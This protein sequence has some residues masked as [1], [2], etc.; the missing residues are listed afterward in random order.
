MSSPDR[1]TL[2]SSLEI[3]VRYGDA[4][5]ERLSELRA[6]L[7]RLE[8]VA[9]D[10]VEP[11]SEPIET[12]H[13]AE[14]VFTEDVTELPAETDVSEPVVAVT[15]APEVVSAAPE[16]GVAAVRHWAVDDDPAL[17]AAFLRQQFASTG[18]GSEPDGDADETPTASKRTN[19]AVVSFDEDGRITYCNE[20]M[21]KLLIDVDGPLV[22][23]RIWEHLPENVIDDVRAVVDRVLET[24]TATT[25]D[26]G[27]DEYGQQFALTVFPSGDGVSVHA[28]THTPREPRPQGRSLY[29]YLI[30]TVGDAV[31]ILDT[32]GRFTFVNEA[33]CEMTGYDRETLIGSS[34]HLIKDDY[35]VEEAEDAL[36]DLLRRRHDDNEEGIGIAKLDVELVTKDGRHI[37]CTDRM[38]LRPM[39]NGEFTGTV[40]TLRDISRQ[41]RRENILGGLLEAAGEMVTAETLEAV[42]ESVLGTAA[43]T[44]DIELATIREYD[45]ETDR[46]VPVVS[47]EAV[48]EVLPERPVYDAD[49]G[50]VGTAFS[51]G[52]LVVEEDMFHL[53][54][55]L[56]PVESSV[57][58][59]LG[60]RRTLSVGIPEG[61]DFDEDERRFVELLAATAA[62]V[63]DRVE[64]EQERRRYEAVVE[65][66]DDMLFTLA[67]GEFTLVTES[68]AA[69]LGRDRDSVR[70]TDIGSVVADVDIAAAMT[71]GVDEITTYE[72]ELV[73]DAGDALPSRISV[74]PI[75]GEVDAGVVGTVRDISDLRSA[76]R[77]ATEQRRRFNELFETLADPVAD[78]LYVDGEPI[79]RNVNPAFADL[80]ASDDADLRDT[81][82]RGVQ[83]RLPDGVA[84]A[85][86]PMGEPE[87]AIER[88]VSARTPGGERHYL[89]KTVPYEGDG[90][91]RAFVILTDVTD[92]KQRETQLEVLYRLLRHNLRNRTTVIQ[93][94]AE[95]IVV[96]DESGEFEA[97]G[98]RIVSASQDLVEASDN[99]RTIQQ[100][101]ENTESVEPTAVADLASELESTLATNFDADVPVRV[102]TAGA[103][104]ASSD[105]STAV[106]ELVENALEH[107]ADEPAVEVTITERPDGD[108]SIAVHDDGPGIPDHEWA[109]VTGDREITQLQHAS[110]LGLWLVKWVADKHGGTLRRDEN[111]DRTTVALDLPR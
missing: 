51:E 19:D 11:V 34:V 97:M 31:Y 40:G 42:D 50:P 109:V 39:E 3:A 111:G 95:E 55:R 69:A 21:E 13:D 15:T 103:V 18:V 89:L 90:V 49:E 79:V 57:Y 26:V 87:T 76:Q 28:R 45:S 5:A 108:V 104:A 64:R 99:A 10:I 68:F 14:L 33:L 22:G 46:L 93:G 56:P 71:A 37:P 41:K 8:T 106:R 88:N 75:E 4:Y 52:E 110:G 30:Q 24:E 36:R 12:D 82:L 35:T 58:L 29:E 80:T 92:V 67:D 47:T 6:A 105:L 81:P 86:A 83:A 59:P 48:E 32:E 23:D 38:T 62:P 61:T 84:D 100:V 98:E 66:A 102:E 91:Q 85:L 9:V 54:E 44:L 25:A 7:D 78:L 16:R 70:G 60:E 2:D 27:L 96:R 72:T 1:A 73:T 101:L 17:L 43:G 77:E 74:A 20:T 65:A 107:A 53:D 63:Y 94:T